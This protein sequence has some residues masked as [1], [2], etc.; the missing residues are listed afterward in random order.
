MLSWDPGHGL[1]IKGNEAGGVAVKKEKSRK[2]GKSRQVKRPDIN[3]VIMTEGWP[4]F[5]EIL[6]FHETMMS[7]NDS[8]R[9]KKTLC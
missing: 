2:K 9:V 8:L 3:L 5:K 4:N 1:P 7:V 6:G